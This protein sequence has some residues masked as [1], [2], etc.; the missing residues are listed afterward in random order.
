MNKEKKEKL[1]KFINDPD[2]K[3]ME[4]IIEGYIEPLR[5]VNTIKS[6][7]PAEEVK[8]EVKTRQRAYAQLRAFLED[9]KVLSQ[10]SDKKEITFE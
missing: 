8:A 3:L 6:D 7:L 2:W 9:A 5:D 10:R 1:L 4:E